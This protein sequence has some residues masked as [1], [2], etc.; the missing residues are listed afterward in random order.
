MALGAEAG[1]I[2]RLVLRQAAALSGAGVV[3]GLIASFWATRLMRGL[4]VGVPPLDV[5]TYALAALAFFA[6]AMLACW[7][8]VRRAAHVDPVVALRED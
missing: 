3:V 1:G 6:V 2:L 5:P 4:L 7:A 8:P